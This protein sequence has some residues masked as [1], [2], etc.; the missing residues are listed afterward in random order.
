MKESAYNIL[1][2]GATGFLGSH[3]L[4]RLLISGHH[5]VA[6]KRT[7][8]DTS[9]VHKWMDHSNLRFYDI[10]KIDP[11]VMFD[12]NQIDIIIHTA[13]EYGRIKKPISEILE[14]NLVLPL[15]L[16]E[17]GIE[18]GTVCFLNTD[19]FSNRGNS[20]HSN[21]LKYSL[22]KKSLLVWLRELSKQVKVV[23]IVL[24]HVYGPYDSRS[25]FVESVIQQVAVERILRV[26][27]TQGF[28]KRDFIYV[29]DVVD[30]YMCLIEHGISHE[31]SFEEFEVGTGTS[32]RI[33]DL[34]ETIKKVANSKTKLG[35]GD[36]PIR[37]NEAMDSKA[38]IAALKE[39][40]WIPKTTMEEG[41]SGILTAYGVEV[42]GA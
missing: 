4:S 29:E 11:S 12:E 21:L 18:H 8:S 23:N 14:P 37:D 20:I 31:F 42:S 9:R 24:E 41:L 30:A 17:L 39:L 33:R 22:S 32:T 27:L 13:T 36:L 26:G 5:V 10:S 19:S 34:A 15:R 3:L 40:G 6:T 38:N 28:Q 16:I 1:L 7:N 2:T 25:K 35:F